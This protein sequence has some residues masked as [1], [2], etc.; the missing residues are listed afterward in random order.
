MKLIPSSSFTP[1][2]SGDG[3]D[4]IRPFGNGD[5]PLFFEGT[6]GEGRGVLH[7]AGLD[8]D[9]KL[10]VG[11]IYDFAEWWR[12]FDGAFGATS[13]HARCVLEGVV[14][15]R[16]SWMSSADMEGCGFVNSIDHNPEG[17]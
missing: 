4:G 6:D 3:L 11:F 17:R 9:G 10:R 15:P 16:P 12:S 14:W 5:L 7:F 2:I 13:E 8:D 1:S